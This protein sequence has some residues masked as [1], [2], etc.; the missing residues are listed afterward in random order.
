M[1]RVKESF[2]R[3]RRD[4]A[5]GAAAMRN[6]EHHL[7]DSAQSAS[8]YGDQGRFGSE[9]EELR[10]LNDQVK[11]AYDQGDYNYL[12][13]RAQKAYQFAKQHFGHGSREAFISLNSLAAV[14]QTE[15]QYG[16]AERGYIQARQGLEEVVGLEH[17]ETI[18]SMNNLAT[19][20]KIQGRYEE[21]E[22]LFKDALQIAGKTE[23]LGLKHPDTLSI[24][25]NLAMMYRAR[26]H[27]QEAEKHYDFV[28]RHRLEIYGRDHPKTLSSLNNLALLYQYQGRYAEAES[29]Y[30]EALETMKRSL[31]PNDPITLACLNNLALFY[32]F[33]GKLNQADRQFSETLDLYKTKFGLQHPRTLRV[34][35]NHARLLVAMGQVEKATEGLRQIG[36]QLFEWT[37]DELYSIQKARVRRQLLFSQADFQDVVLSLAILHPLPDIIRLAA[38]TM[39]RWKRVQ[40]EEEAFI[41]NLVNRS[42]ISQVVELGKKLEELRSQL[43][44]LYHTGQPIRKTLEEMEKTR[45]DLAQLSRDYRM[46]RKGRAVDLQQLIRSIPPNS[47]LIELKQFRM[48]DFTNRKKGDW[49]W[50]GLMVMANS[51]NPVLKDLGPMVHSNKWLEEAT[52]EQ[53]RSIIFVGA[54]EKKVAGQE[55]KINWAEQIYRILFMP[56]EPEIAGLKTVYLAPDGALHLIPFHCL[57]LPDK[58]Y[59]IQRQMIRILQSGRDLIK[60][61]YAPLSS[62][63]LAFGGIDF[64]IYTNPV[65]SEPSD[66]KQNDKFANPHLSE[67]FD[68]FPNL[69]FS[70]E[71]VDTISDLYR[72][73]YGDDSVR[74]WYNSKARESRLKSIQ[75]A[76]RILHLATHGFYSS[77]KKGVERPLL[78]SGLAMADAN[79]GLAGRVAQDRDDGILY[80]LEA[81]GLNLRGTEL[82]VL[83]AC[84]TGEGAVDYSEGVY[85]L[86]RAFQLA[87]A[88]AVL[89]TLRQIDDDQAKDFMTSFYKRWLMQPDSNIY[90]ALRLTQLEYINNPNPAVSKPSVWAP[91]VLVGYQ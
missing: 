34:H 41:E 78:L 46:L 37:V 56:F 3:L 75:V 88:S 29:L 16:E 64:G 18:K 1:Y 79:V 87:G 2:D 6:F 69:P 39:L 14:Y 84:R 90:T 77:S 30:Q 76:P 36:D 12:L 47:A 91:Y 4:V 60:Q 44:Y 71:E 31:K 27:Y 49:H 38:D 22:P 74:V 58:R 26:K 33:Q 48:I 66:T 19:L 5:R 13:R 43:A 54:S 52:T 86:V 45:L 70:R 82:V 8:P 68:G 50:A 85:G 73:K 21:A 20:Y 25:D 65:I 57:V 35:M 23:G 40:G 63:L 59:W 80:A 89:M 42:Q 72:H 51:E 61:S 32:Q 55:E 53:G 24:Q 15:G 81:V 11:S 83:S 67:S 17:T 9:H 62:R 10:R 7:V 28:L